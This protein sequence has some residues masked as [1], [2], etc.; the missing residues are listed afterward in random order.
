MGR[1]QR[2]AAVRIGVALS[3]AWSTR[4]AAQPEAPATEVTGSESES[5][6]DN[7]TSSALEPA[8]WSLRLSAGGGIG[9]REFAW[10]MDGSI[11]QARTGV[12]PAVDLGFDLDHVVS[13]AIQVGLLVRYQ[14]SIGLVLV[15]HLTNGDEQARDAR[16]HRLEL[17]IVPTVRFDARRRWALSGAIGYGISDFRPQGHLVTPAYFLAGP[18]LRVELQL[19]LGSDRVRLR[20]G[21]EAQWI[22]QI[23]QELVQRSV[24]TGGWGV[25][26]AAALEVVL[27]QRWI[28]AATYRE[29]RSWLDSP[30]S[31]TFED[32][33]RFVT[34]RLTGAL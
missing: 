15:E 12:F 27:S 34:G 9:S 6:H 11:N 14:S 5:S 2:W 33:T 29:L 28:L 4:A 25:G 31:G 19:P 1:G 30:P 8:T 24:A 21:P 18:Y 3:A 17:G 20:V 16:S 26:G 13:K 7:G 10:P 32:V 22:V 23:G